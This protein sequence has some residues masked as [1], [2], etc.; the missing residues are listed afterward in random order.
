[1]KLTL[2]PYKDPTS[3]GL[4]SAA[5]IRVTYFGRAW[6]VP[7]EH[8]RTWAALWSTFTKAFIE[9]AW[10]LA[11]IHESVV[12]DAARWESLQRQTATGVVKLQL[13]KRADQRVIGS[14]LVLQQELEIVS[15]IRKSSNETSSK[16][17]SGPASNTGFGQLIDASPLVHLLRSRATPPAASEVTSTVAEDLHSMLSNSPNLLVRSTYTN[18]KGATRRRFLDEFEMVAA[19]LGDDR[20]LKMKC[21]L[22]VHAYYL[23]TF[24]W[25]WDSQHTVLSRFWEAL[26]AICSL[27]D[28]GATSVGFHCLFRYNRWIANA[29]LHAGME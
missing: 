15:A 24:F 23:Y 8:C 25:A 29:H 7:L 14:V 6:V 21:D 27:K 9:R 1:M 4:E 17:T 11:F 5:Q 19:G 10:G 2:H 20:F 13:V 16:T 3:G 26:C 28:S 12:L 18:F 22:A